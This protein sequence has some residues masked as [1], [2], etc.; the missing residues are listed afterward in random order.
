MED[1]YFSKCGRTCKVYLIFYGT[2]QFVALACLVKIKNWSCKIFGEIADEAVTVIVEILSFAGNFEFWS[3]PSWCLF[4]IHHKFWLS[5]KEWK[6]RGA[7]I[8][9]ALL[10]SSKSAF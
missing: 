4:R 7:E 2:D 1:L 3:N 10:I 5:Q 9:T 8:Y 6:L